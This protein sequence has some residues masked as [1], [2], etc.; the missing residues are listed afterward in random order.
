MVIRCLLS[1][2]NDPV[3]EHYRSK[4][5]EQRVTENDLKPWIF[6]CPRWYPFAVSPPITYTQ[7]KNEALQGDYVQDVATQAASG[8]EP[9]VAREGH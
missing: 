7:A 8:V 6:L 5:P 1:F 4:S 3:A 9:C 2:R